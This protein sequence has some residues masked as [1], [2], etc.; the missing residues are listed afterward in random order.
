M[1]YTNI[2]WIKV[3]LDLFND[4]RFLY[5]LSDEEQLMYLKM[6]VLAGITK[7]NIPADPEF[8]KG[9]VNFRSNDG[10]I[11][12]ILDKLMK[13]FPKFKKNKNGNYCFAKF[14]KFHNRIND[15]EIGGSTT[16]RGV[17]RKPEGSPK[18]LQRGVLEK[19][20]EEKRR[21]EKRREESTYGQ[22]KEL[23]DRLWTSYPKRT[24]RK[25]AERYFKSSVKN[26]QDEKDIETA[27]K[28]YL[29]SE[30]VFKGFIQD[31]GTWFNNWRDWI[32][33]KED[34][35]PKCKGKGKF[36]SATGYE[37]IC[38]CKAGAAIQ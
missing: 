13:V 5:L 27:L 21:E 28:N 22:N 3:Y 24:K 14:N 12:E 2:V 8:I 16:S 18:E 30:R 26:E 31:G 20:R 11:G 19:R 36:V 17:R 33:Y 10:Q 38:D 4:E 37:I 15:R 1:P 9:K 34:I 32:D 23:F 35:C 6:L 7:N 25:M 29:A